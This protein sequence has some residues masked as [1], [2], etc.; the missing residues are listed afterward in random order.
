MIRSSVTVEDTS[1]YM[2]QVAILSV[3]TVCHFKSQELVLCEYN[4]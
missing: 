4:H 1:Q 2:G 3:L